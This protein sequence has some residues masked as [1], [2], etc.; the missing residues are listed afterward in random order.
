[1]SYMYVYVEKVYMGDIKAYNLINMQIWRHA[2]KTKTIDKI[3]PL[4]QQFSDFA[5]LRIYT[6]IQHE[7]II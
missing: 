4:K 1:M 2:K 3:E 7:Y 5:M 6:I